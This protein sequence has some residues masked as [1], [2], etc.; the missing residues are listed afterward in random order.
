MNEAKRLLVQD[1]FTKAQHDL[2]G[3][4]KVSAE[5]NPLYDLAVYHCQQ[6]GEKAVK[7][8][9][10]YCDQPFEKSHDIVEMVDLAIP[11]DKQFSNWRTIARELTPF[12]F[13]FRYPG[14]AASGPTKGQYKDAITKATDLYN[15]VLS[16][17]PPETHPPEPKPQPPTDSE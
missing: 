15:F 5:P 11:F 8:Y 16:I 10:V 17:V 6:A 7:G 13:K 2:E 12:A 4:H 9:L 14:F 3:A 1:W